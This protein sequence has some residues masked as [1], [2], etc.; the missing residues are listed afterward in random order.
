MDDNVKAASYIAFAAVTFAAFPVV[1]IIFEIEATAVPFTLFISVLLSTLFFA[2]IN[3]LN[4][5]S[6]RQSLALCT[7]KETK[8]YFILRGI[9]GL[10]I[11]FL[12]LAFYQTNTHYLVTLL[13]ESYPLISALVA[14]LIFGK[15]GATLR[16]K[17]G[18]YL[19]GFAA[20]AAG[21]AFYFGLSLIATISVIIAI[22]LSAL[23]SVTEP[24]LNAVL[25]KTTPSKSNFELSILNKFSTSL[26]TLALSLIY[27]LLFVDL[28]EIN[29][30]RSLMAAAVAFAVIDIVAGLCSRLA[31]A[32]IVNPKV[33][34]LWYL[35]PF[36]SFVF[37][38]WFS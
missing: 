11:F 9:A 14:I 12:A 37:I 15:A 22:Y 29:I 33:F 24:K 20:L 5:N 32:H 1:T 31:G 13:T 25:L 6:A 8:I 2:W 10:N 30:T 7:A 3:R 18:I 19:V 35:T 36:T 21:V 17:V 34:L 27:V 28:S 4:S 16:F 38:Y 26:F 23:S